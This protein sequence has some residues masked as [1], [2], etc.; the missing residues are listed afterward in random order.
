MHDSC[1]FHLALAGNKLKDTECDLEELCSC[2]RDN[3]TLQRF[4]RWDISWVV[5]GRK[6]YSCYLVAVLEIELQL[7][8]LMWLRSN[9]QVAGMGVRV[10]EGI[11]EQRASHSC[12]T[13]R[14]VR[15]WTHT[16]I[17]TQI[18]RQPQTHMDTHP[19]AHIGTLT[20][21]NTRRCIQTQSLRYTQ[22]HPHE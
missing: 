12:Q 9:W 18:H 3:R 22:R 1:A 17:H 15:K 5:I 4:I 21:A 14:H 7:P 19:Y 20:D 6:L 16:Q 8:L 13:L 10:R 11:W 2:L